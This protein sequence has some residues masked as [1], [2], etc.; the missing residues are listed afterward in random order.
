VYG[1]VFGAEAVGA[2]EEEKWAVVVGL[3]R[4]EG[5]VSGCDAESR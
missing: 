2:R 5:R 3:C 4:A 1:E